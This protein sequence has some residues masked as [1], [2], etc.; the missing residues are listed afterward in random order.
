MPR[1]APPELGIYQPGDRLYRFETTLYYPVQSLPTVAECPRCGSMQRL[2][3][4]AL[5]LAEG[6]TDVRVWP[7]TSLVRLEDSEKSP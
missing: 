3:A 7:R 5:Q 6:T 4:D 1:D 2:F